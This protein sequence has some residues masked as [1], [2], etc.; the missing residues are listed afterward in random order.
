MGVKGLLSFLKDKMDSVDLFDVA[1]ERD[2]IEILAD[3][4]AFENALLMSMW[5]VLDEEVY[6]NYYLRLG[7]GEYDNIDKYLKNVIYDLRSHGVE[8]VFYVDGARGSSTY[9]CERKLDKWKEGHKGLLKKLRHPLEVCSGTKW[10]LPFDPAVLPV[11]LEAQFFQTLKECMCE[12][13]QLAS[14][15]V[16]YTVANDL[17]KRPKAYAILGNDTDFCIFKESVFI[18]VDQFKMPT[19]L[20]LGTGPNAELN[21]LP[22]QVITQE[23][24]SD[25]LGFGHHSELI[26]FAILCGNDFTFPELNR[27]NLK[28]KLGL[29]NRWEQHIREV[30]YWVKANNKVDNHPLVVQEEKLMKGVHYSRIFYSLGPLSSEPV[31]TGGE[32]TNHIAKGITEIKYPATVMSM[33]NKFYWHRH[34]L[35]DTSPGQPSVEEELTELRRYIYKFLLPGDEDFVMEHGRTPHKDLVER[36]VTPSSKFS[37]DLL[38]IHQICPDDLQKNLETFHTIMTHQEHGSAFRMS[39]SHY[40]KRTSFLACVLRYFLIMNKGKNLNITHEEFHALA[41]MAF[42]KD[43]ALNVEFYIGLAI[44]PSVRCVTIGNWFQ[45]V[46]RYAFDYIGKIL[47]V[48]HEFP[49]PREVFSGS[50]WTAF[51]MLRSAREEVF[52]MKWKHPVRIEHSDQ[53]RVDNEMKKIIEGRTGVLLDIMEGYLLPHDVSTPHE[54]RGQQHRGSQPPIY[55]RGAGQSQR[56]TTA[57]THPGGARGNRGGAYGYSLDHY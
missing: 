41:A 14:G 4:Y 9:Q 10:G 53:G 12:I 34:L 16:D 3:F 27:L 52:A 50:V 29:R 7:L 5:R 33:H 54:A 18:H 57:Q 32:M 30:A 35:E 40:D 55:G 11:L 1:R 49:L 23:K 56:W 22:A 36:K 42:A 48:S 13:N 46:F 44:R 39:I 6:G 19:D 26:E 15:E 37:I 8:L 38:R 47:R 45:A 31:G 28:E 17:V 51:Y 21:S 24:L 43:A 25:I 20:G 2:G